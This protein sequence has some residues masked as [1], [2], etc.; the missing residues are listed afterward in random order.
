MWGVTFF[1]ASAVLRVCVCILWVESI[2][3][4][5]KKLA[6]FFL[7]NFIFKASLKKTLKT[8]QMLKKARDNLSRRKKKDQKLICYF[9][10]NF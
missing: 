4:S 3:S 2:F 6:Q 8:V 1:N 7:K 9:A 10:F 5:H